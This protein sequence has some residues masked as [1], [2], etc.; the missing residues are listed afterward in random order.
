MKSTI[1]S[2]V[3]VLHSKVCDLTERVQTLE[4]SSDKVDKLS[5]RLQLLENKFSNHPTPPWGS[6]SSHIRY[7]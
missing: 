6:S 4:S 7:S 2:E 1:E 5:D 3:K